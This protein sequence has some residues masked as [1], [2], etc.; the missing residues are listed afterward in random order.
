M[1][2]EQL[3]KKHIGKS[4]DFHWRGQEVTRIEGFS[5]AVFAFAVTLLV[6]SLEVPKTFCELLDAMLGFI[7]FALCFALL[8]LTWYEHYTFFRRYGFQNGYTVVLNATLLFVVLFYVYPLKFLFSLMVREILDAPIR[9]IVFT[10]GCSTMESTSGI[11]NSTQ[12]SSLMIIFGLGYIAVAVVFV[13]LYLQAYRRRAELKLNELEVFDTRE[14]IAVQ[15][16]NIGVGVASLFIVALGGG[17]FVAGAGW[18][19]AFIGPLQTVLGIFMGSRRRK[20]EESFMASE[21]N[22]ESSEI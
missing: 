5:D 18:C 3:M 16:L 1:I 14:S 6:V 4:T 22:A 17:N 12:A 13:S 21:N 2:R 19:Y 20:L 8:I 11:T 7:A 10:N 15:L 9:Q